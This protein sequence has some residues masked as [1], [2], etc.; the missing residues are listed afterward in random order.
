MTKILKAIYRLAGETQIKLI[1][2]EYLEGIH[3]GFVFSDFLGNEAFT[4]PPQNLKYISPDEVL[5]YQFNC[6]NETEWEETL[7]DDYDF[8]YTIIQ[9]EI[10]HKHINKAILSRKKVENKR[11]VPAELFLKMCDEYKSSH[12]FLVE[13]PKG[14]NWIGATPE[15]LISKKENHFSTMSLAGTKDSIDKAWT[16]KEYDEQKIVTN[17]ILAELFKLNIDPSIGELETVKAGVVYHLKNEISFEGNNSLHEIAKVLHPTP[18][19]S[20]NP[21]KQAISTIKIA[22]NYNREFYCGF[23]GPNEIGEQSL[24]FVNLRCASISKNQIC[25]YV[26]GGITKNSTLELEWEECERKAQSI[27]RFI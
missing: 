3:K 1:E 17:A 27:L 18:A 25:L 8:G 20:G 9:N 23:G 13:T 26:G 12:V 21:K 14:Y 7:R 15:T 24:L 11:L 16:D 19:I 5:D 10:E 6:D 4:I 2:G 22:E